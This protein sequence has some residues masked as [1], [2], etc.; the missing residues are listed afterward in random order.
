MPP[1]PKAQFASILRAT[2]ACT[3]QAFISGVNQVGMDRRAARWR[4]GRGFKPSVG[5]GWGAIPP[6]RGAGLFAR[7]GQAGR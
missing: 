3:E 7:R 6:A 1:P 2:P 5:A 4:S